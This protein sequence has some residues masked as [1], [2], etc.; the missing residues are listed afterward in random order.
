MHVLCPYRVIVL[1]RA[2]VVPLVTVTVIK[3]ACALLSEHTYLVLLLVSTSYIIIV[4]PYSYFYTLIISIV[5]PIS[6]SSPPPRPPTYKIFRR[7]NIYLYS[8]KKCV[9][10][11]DISY[12][13]YG[14]Y[15]LLAA[16]VRARKPIPIHGSHHDSNNHKP[17][18]TK[19]YMCLS[20]NC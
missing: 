12:Y 20:M 18:Q 16:G 6:L 17:C 8:N 7:Y 4:Y 10:Y 15:L 11:Y 19:N 1:L 2:I 13:Y 5:V 14:R 3:N 9:C